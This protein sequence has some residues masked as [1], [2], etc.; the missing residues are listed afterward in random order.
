VTQGLNRDAGEFSEFV[1]LIQPAH[2]PLRDMVSFDLRS[3]SSDV[4][5]MLRGGCPTRNSAWYA[6]KL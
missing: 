4:I 2:R 6:L 1:D 5:F 3:G